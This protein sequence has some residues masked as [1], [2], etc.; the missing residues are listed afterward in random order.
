M[1]AGGLGGWVCVCL[2][3]GGGVQKKGSI[4]K[5]KKNVEK[6]ASKYIRFCFGWLGYNLS[7]ACVC[8][9]ACITRAITKRGPSFNYGGLNHEFLLGS[10]QGCEKYAYPVLVGKGL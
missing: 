6:K 10:T 7:C 1:K 4:A 3:G 9:H 2:E 8:V 5:K